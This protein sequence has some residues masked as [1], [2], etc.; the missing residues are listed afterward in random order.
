M[1]HKFYNWCVSRKTF[2]YRNA[3]SAFLIV[4]NLNTAA[5]IVPEKKK[6]N[7]F[8]GILVRNM[9]RFY[10]LRLVIFVNCCALSVNSHLGA[11]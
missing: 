5:V 10:R 2:V 4:L 7:T 3:R 1:S 6:I 8:D 11:V 9:N